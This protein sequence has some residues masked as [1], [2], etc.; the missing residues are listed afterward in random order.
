MELHAA[1][2]NGPV[3]ETTAPHFSVAARRPEKPAESTTEIIPGNRGMVGGSWCHPPLL[4]AKAVMAGRYHQFLWP[5]SC[6]VSLHESG[7]E[8]QGAN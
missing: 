6:P 5:E 4:A 2:G 8:R 3:A 1:E 7:A